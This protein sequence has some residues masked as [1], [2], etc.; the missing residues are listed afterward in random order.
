VLPL[1]RRIAVGAGRYNEIGI[2]LFQNLVEGR[3]HPPT[4][5]NEI[6]RSGKEMKRTRGEKTQHRKK[7]ES[8]NPNPN[9]IDK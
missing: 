5:K 4:K 6:K 8:A 1:E 2:H 3:T 9:Q 7:P